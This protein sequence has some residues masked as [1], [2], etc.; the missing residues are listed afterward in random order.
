MP[1][2]RISTLTAC[3]P[4]E[5]S[6]CGASPAHGSECRLQKVDDQEKHHAHHD[7]ADDNDL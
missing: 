2:H 1:W 5:G 3:R 7:D 4:Y 6:P